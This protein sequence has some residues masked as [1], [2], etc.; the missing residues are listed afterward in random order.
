MNWGAGTAARCTWPGRRVASG[1]PVRL[2]VQHLG[3]ARSM[4]FL[5]RKRIV[6][7]D[8]AFELCLVHEVCPAEELASL[9]V[10]ATMV[11]GRWTHR[12]ADL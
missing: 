1:S 6:S 5:M 8:E 3:V 10:A 9:R 12:S 2:L 7:V 4:D 11:G